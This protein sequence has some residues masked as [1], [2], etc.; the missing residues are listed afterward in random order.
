MN[1]ET[2]RDTYLKFSQ[3]FNAANVFPH[4]QASYQKTVVYLTHRYPFMFSPYLEKLESL[5]VIDSM[6]DY[7][8]FLKYT[9]AQLKLF[10]SLKISIIEWVRILS[11]Q[12][13]LS[14]KFLLQRLQRSTKKSLFD[15]YLLWSISQIVEKVFFEKHNPLPQKYIIKKESSVDVSA[16]K[17]E[18]RHMDPFW[19][20]STT[21]QQQL[22]HHQ[23][24]QAIILRI[25]QNLVEVPVP[26]DGPH[27]SVRTTEA[28]LFKNALAFAENFAQ[29]N[30]LGLG[31]VALVRLRPNELVYRHT[32]HEIQLRNRARF[33]LVV[34]SSEGNYL[35]LG[36]EIT[37]IQEGEFWEYGNKTTHKSYNTSNSWRTNLIFD[38]YPAQ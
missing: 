26:V 10:L 2:F 15:T 21:R 13:V 6:R 27:E 11:F 30:N 8:D 17:E 32:D 5:E 28:L 7:E 1:L 35:M 25:V 31:R 33:H 19:F 4:S 37:H 38:T 29:T 3:E 36:D 14:L 22:L 16:M 24:T 23:H 18:L 9:Y 20:M 12:D 34:D